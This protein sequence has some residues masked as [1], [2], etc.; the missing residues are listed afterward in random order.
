[1]ERQSAYRS[2]QARAA[3]LAAY[4]DALSR[5]PVTYET[6]FID[7]SFGQ[8]HV[9]VCGPPEAPPLVLLHGAV[10]NATAW[11]PNV[12]SLARG[13]RL[14]AP[15]VIG[16]LG[17]SAGTRPTYKSDD[18]AYWLAEVVDGLGLDRPSVCGASLGGWLAHRFA[19]RFPD[20]V[21]RLALIAPASLQRMRVWFVVRWIL[22]AA[23]PRPSVLRSFRKYLSSPNST[24]PPES[25]FESFLIRWR[26]QRPNPH[27]VP[28]ISDGDLS[29]LPPR[30]LLL[31]G[32]DDVIYDTAKAA[33]RVQSVAPSIKVSVIPDAGH[34]LAADRPQ[35]VNDELLNFFC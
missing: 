21:D 14:F 8:T 24:E 25:A 12:A 33:A 31:L 1:M 26:A 13:L 20:K 23:V 19:L 4:D 10:G 30:T 28:V 18:H 16:D 9:V 32:R 3:V 6:K 5:W 15:D 7:T 17:K 29:R 35:V 2:E 11:A 22:A 27:Y 34:A